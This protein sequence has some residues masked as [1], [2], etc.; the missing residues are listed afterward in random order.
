MRR[1]D[2][3]KQLA[4]TAGG[5]VCGL[6]PLGASP[7]RQ[8]QQ[9]A[10]PAAFP[11]RGLIEKDGTLFQPV[12]LS[13][14]PADAGSTAICRIDGA[15]RLRQIIAPDSRTIDILAPAVDAERTVNVE[16]TIAGRTNSYSVTL[17]PVR[18]V[19]IYVLPHSHNDIGYTDLQA[20]V[21]EKQIRNLH[22]GI[23]L[24][25]RTA[26]YPEGAR[27]A[28]NM[29]G[30]WAVDMF[31]RRASDDEKNEF[32]DAVQ[33]GWVALNGMY[34]NELTGLCRPEE[35]LQLFRYA[36]Q[37]A[38]QCR[39][40][41]DSAMISDVPGFTWGTATAMS[42]AGIRY[43]SAAPNFFDRI[44]SIMEQWQDK[45][46][47]WLSPSGKEKILVWVP[48]TG[49]A[50]SHVVRQASDQWVNDYQD[51]L[52]QV[53]F[54]YDISYIRWSGHGDNAEPDPQICE[55]FKE[56]NTKY[57]WP[58]FAISS[59]STAFRAFEEAHGAQLPEFKG[60]L[61][62]YWEDGAAS[63]ARETAINR[64][65]AERLVQAEALFAMTAAN[66]YEAPYP[67]AAFDDAWRN[68]LLYS[69]HTWGAWNSVSDSENPFVKAQWETKATF[70]IRASRQS[71]ELLD[72]SL[73]PASAGG[74]LETV[75]P[76]GAI[77]IYNT[78]SWPRSEIV[79]VPGVMSPL[80]CVTDANG[81][82]VPS[83]RLMRDE[84]AIP[85][86][87]YD[88]YEPGQLAILAADIPP[89]ASARFQISPKPPHPPARPVSI[90]GTVLDNGIV[91][92]RVDPKTGGII[93]LLRHD[94]DHN[95]ADTSGTEQINQYLYLAGADLADLQTN[96]TP[97]I[98]VEANG[99]LVAILR[100]E[101]EAPGC[102]SLVRKVR[103]CAG[104][105][106]LELTNIVDKKRAPM[107]PTPAKGDWA[108]RGGKESVQFAFP[109]N[110]PNGQ[111]RIDI[112]LAVMRPEIDQLPGAC[113]NWLPVGRWVDVANDRLGVTWATLD[114]PLLEIGEISARML[115][116]QTKPD[117]W[118]KHIEPTQKFYS[119]V[120]NN[121]WRTNYRAY[122]EGVVAFRYALRPHIL[123]Q[124]RGYDPAAAARFSTALTQ[125]LV[126]ARAPTDAA[127]DAPRLP[128]VRVEPADVLVTTL[129]SSDDGEAWII[130]LFGASGENRQA[131]LIW[132][133]AQ[134]ESLWLSDLSEKPLT[135]VSG[136]VSV[137]AW[138]LVTLRA[139]KALKG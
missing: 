91:R 115:G 37:L 70:A 13:V 19:R 89:F 131:K 95:F 14:T 71:R 124:E 2:L 29:E 100:I 112:P 106:Y 74:I 118:R 9:A 30:L 22:Q 43:F 101:S 85:V 57:A 65:T 49:Y 1:R 127:D 122:Q 54:P 105:D 87:Q 80:D 4:A 90:D 56:W 94:D 60:D 53:N 78:T 5:L 18:K 33:K 111:L 34:A 138:S 31:M 79:R 126:A 97:R 25:R 20:A 92:A 36:T 17:K 64:N 84:L 72:R 61:T 11:I 46:F 23:D 114:A 103:L 62:P 130:R 76:R 12:R 52:D 110:V 123:H 77:E 139:A 16:V 102:K 28:W 117:I 27:F 63:S 99:P 8:E 3:L 109:F 104:A 129:K 21:E 133:Y 75:S 86:E 134:P 125:P 44:G 24:A 136:A 35:L 73:G 98:T 39:V 88:Y 50:M 67:S 47:W 42:Q 6:R 135:R 41:I 93:E 69:E 116:S 66:G 82:P 26:A 38:D 55:F 107:N 58:K 108:Q 10:T 7:E 68:V 96:E 83:Q 32:I 132:P 120:M 51:R 59:T 121:H 128:L 48:W 137:P 119:W 81:R 15:E 113:K 40:Q 45:P